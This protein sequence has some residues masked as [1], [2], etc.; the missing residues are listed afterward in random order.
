MLS[1]GRL[2]ISVY[3]VLKRDWRRHSTASFRENVV[4]AILGSIF[5]FLRTIYEDYFLTICQKNIQI[6]LRPRSRLLPQT[7]GLRS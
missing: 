7:K 1:G 4:E 2:R 6:K 5:S 3:F